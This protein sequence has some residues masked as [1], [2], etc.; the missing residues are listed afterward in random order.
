MPSD[1]QRLHV[2]VL[3]AGEGKRMRSPLPKVLHPLG[4][5]PLVVHVLRTA[6]ALGAQAITVVHGHGGGRLQEALANEPDLLWAHQD[7]QLGTGHA[8]DAA[9]PG[10]GAHERVLVLYGDVP[11]LTEATLRSLLDAAGDGGAMLAERMDV[12]T[13]YGRVLLDDAGR[14]RAVVEE[15]DA[16]EAQRRTTLVNTGVL[17][18]TAADLRAWLARVGNDNAQKEYYLTDVFALAAADG[19]PFACV[20]CREA[21][22]ADG[23]NDPWQLAQL[24][25]RL[26][27]RR[28]R[29]L[30]LA[31]MRIADPARFDVR[32]T[33]EAGRD[34]FVDVDVV[35]EGR[36][37]LGDGVQVGPFCR[38][39][40]VVLGPGTVVHAHCDI[41]GA[42]AG[43]AAVIGP[44]ARLR[45]GT[46]LADDV[47]VGNFVE[48]KKARLGRGSKANHLSYL[49]DAE[50]GS[51]VNVGAGTITCNYDGA[52]KHLTRIGDG[53]FIGSNTALVAPVTVGAGATI[54]AGSTIGKDAPAGELTVARARQATIPG[55]QRPVK[56]T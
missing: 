26:Q 28:A 3:A 54:G 15:K 35:L 34:V 17:T 16:N 47:H 40:D 52:N 31:G 36:V 51:K 49:G 41:E 50:I 37:V 24:E 19:R 30:A 29:E 8:V 39:R 20:P 10:V 48:T 44:F 7:R 43:A 27:L 11:L 42:V 45:P 53:A 9:L 55:W 13:G 12:P 33:V 21:G 18:A 2:V 38:L 23:V 5:A 46:E 22:E 14:V 25:R 56:K 4:D 32:G 6:R 1:S